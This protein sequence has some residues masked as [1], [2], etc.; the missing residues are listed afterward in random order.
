MTVRLLSVTGHAIR[1]TSGEWHSFYQQLQRLLTAGVSLLAA[2]QLLNAHATQQ[3]MRL[4]SWQLAQSVLR[5]QS[6]SEAASK[7]EAFSVLDLSLL[8]VGELSGH[9]ADIFGMLANYHEQH[10]RLASDLKK[11][12][13]YP[14]ALL[15]MSFCVLALMLL[16]LVPQFSQ[17]F[18]TVGVALPWLTRAVLHVAT[19][20]LPISA[21]GA[22]LVVSAYITVK[23]LKRTRVDL[24]ERV[25]QHLPI[26]KTI[27]QLAVWQRFCQSLGLMLQAGVSLLQALPI[28]ATAANSALAWAALY[29][30]QRDLEQGV[31]LPDAFL[32]QRFFPPVLQLLIII[33][34][35]TGRLDLVLLQQALSFEQSL[36]QALAQLNRWLEP[37]VM[38]GVGCVVGVIVIAMY[39]PIFQMG[40]LF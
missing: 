34:E 4:L 15:L 11:A 40:R 36:S 2:L 23:I 29:R 39:L 20:A 35:N 28:S 9:L 17:L 38:I 31:S 33:G 13:A 19:L 24:I 32:K 37:L 30:I 6:F 5:G 16:W 1:L 10:L 21:L 14:I 22:V 12:L 18:L 27:W 25:I 7:S 3:A 26:V 8:A